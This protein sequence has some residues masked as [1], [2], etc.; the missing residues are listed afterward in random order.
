MSRRRHRSDGPWLALRLG[1]TS[2]YK[3]RR[4]SASARPSLESETSLP[5]DDDK[6]GPRRDL[7][8]V[9]GLF[10]A[11]ALAYLS[12]LFTSDGVDGTKPFVEAA[13][14]NATAL[15]AV[16]RLIVHPPWRDDAAEAIRQAG[17]LPKS[18]DVSEA[19]AP[20]YQEAWGQVAFVIDRSAPGL[21]AAY[22]SRISEFGRVLSDDG[23]IRVVIV[24][25]TGKTTA[26][27]GRLLAK[28]MVTVED[29]VGKITRCKWDGG[30]GK[31]VCPGLPSWMHVAE[32]NVATQGKN[33]RCIW[34]HPTSGGK[35]SVRFQGVTVGEKLLLSHALA[36]SALRNKSGAP[37]TASVFVGGT[38]VGRHAKQN[39]AGFESKSFAVPDSKRGKKKNVRV[40]I[41]TRDDGAR[42]YCFRLSS[43]GGKR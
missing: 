24:D 29:K 8:I 33:E 34:A 23:T 15:S 27:F 2:G 13:K 11:L 35:V 36:D 41:T 26:R 4:P 37:V 10:L 18:V 25:D 21:P 38:L 12:P 22:H 31:H 1:L 6:G 32:K 30:A 14:A 3:D 43:E 28:A 5:I 20:K 19:F 17:V 9:I 42:H 16:D 7:A 40:E 39:R